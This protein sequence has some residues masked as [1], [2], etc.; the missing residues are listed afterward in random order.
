MVEQNAEAT[1]R[2]AEL[3]AQNARQAQS[4]AVLA[5]NAKRDSEVMKAIT[6]V[7]LIFLPATFVSVCPIPL[8]ESTAHTLFLSRRFLAWGFSI[9]IRNSSLSH[10]KAGFISLSL[11][12]SPSLSSQRHLRGY[13]GQGGRRRSQLITLLPKCL[14]KLPIRCD[15]ELDVE[16]GLPDEVPLRIKVLCH[17]SHGFLTRLY[18]NNVLLMFQL[19]TC[20]FVWWRYPLLFLC[21]YP[22]LTQMV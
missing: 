19:T 1:K 8:L 4:M 3:A 21:A 16:I 9:S 18:L 12:R 5:Y 11:F 7:T 20:W 2:M 14:H 10:V 22:V 6:V 15:L 13:G 17:I